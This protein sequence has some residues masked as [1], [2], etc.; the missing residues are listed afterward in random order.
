MKN[1]EPRITFGAGAVAIFFVILAG[2][3]GNLKG[4]ADALAAT[5]TREHPA[6]SPDA[7][8]EG[9]G[10]AQAASHDPQRLEKIHKKLSDILKSPTASSSDPELRAQTM[11][12]LAQMSSPEIEA[13]LRSLPSGSE[14]MGGNY[15]MAWC[16]IRWWGMQDCPAALAYLGTCSSARSNT[17]RMMTTGMIMNWTQDQ[18]DAALAWMSEGSLTPQQKERV[19]NIRLNSLM[20]LVESDPDRAFQELSTMTGKDVSGQLT[21][22]GG[23]NGQ[24][25]EIRKRLLDY[26]AGTGNP[27]DLAAV[28]A[29]II[30]A[31]ANKDVE[32]A[33][34]FVLN[35]QA[36]GEERVALDATLTAATARKNP[37]SAYTDWLERNG[38]VT[39]IP[40][41]IRYGISAWLGQ[42]SMGDH[43][44]GAPIKWLDAL[45][46]GDQR[47]AF[48]ESSI[49]ALAG[50]R[51]FDD[52]ARMAGN[53]DSP[54]LRASALNALQTR[55]LLVDSQKAAAW[56]SALSAEDQA[57]LRK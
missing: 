22:W 53:I 27:E 19:S 41:T 29:A 45:P 20:V 2:V 33:K 44:D 5:G 39:E 34:E 9:G 42:S 7:A 54:T 35:L 49:P 37:E 13:F 23:T 43:D 21:N 40:A 24:N 6:H 46:A 47:D 3:G 38:K 16:V 56:K 30:S 52:A 8:G 4:R 11:Q 50:F 57:L 15:L 55:W 28:R 31:M 1:S 12:L 51:H 10:K 14:R 26:A 18:P 36:S 17:T 32:A 48:Y 25:P